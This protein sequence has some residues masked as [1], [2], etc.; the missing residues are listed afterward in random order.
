MVIY[1][2]YWNGTDFLEM[3]ASSVCHLIWEEVLFIC[4]AGCRVEEELSSDRFRKWIS[5]TVEHSK[6]LKGIFLLGWLEG[7]EVDLQRKNAIKSKDQEAVKPFLD[8][9]EDNCLTNLWI[10]RQNCFLLSAQDFQVQVHHEV[11][12]QRMGEEFK[13]DPILFRTFFGSLEK[14]EMAAANEDVGSAAD[15]LAGLQVD[16]K[17]PPLIK[18]DTVQKPAKPKNLD[19]QLPNG[20]F[21]HLLWN[22]DELSSQKLKILTWMLHDMNIDVGFILKAANVHL[23][24]DGRIPGYQIVTPQP[25]S[26]SHAIDPKASNN[27]VL[28]ETRM[29]FVFRGEKTVLPTIYGGLD[30]LGG[31]TKQARVCWFEYKG[32]MYI[33]MHRESETQNNTGSGNFPK[34]LDSK[35]TRVVTAGL[36][37]IVVVG[38]PSNPT[39][40]LGTSRLLNANA[41]DQQKYQ[42][43]RFVDIF[44]RHGFGTNQVVFP[45]PPRWV[46]KDQG[47]RN[48]FILTKNLQ[49]AG[50]PGIGYAFELKGA[51]Q[52]VKRIMGCEAI[53]FSLND[54][55]ATDQGTSKEIKKEEP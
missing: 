30:T 47:M 29:F 28:G 25:C 32:V 51:T 39:Y 22:M 15:G 55:P 35:I 17:K 26:L 41:L 16:D 42:S 49:L 53:F 34:F 36:K 2:K 14:K 50:P 4:V 37:G 33:C 38:I 11:F 18:T 23:R 31:G 27:A 6:D 54:N 12:T 45:A 46:N 3:T 52:P 24:P 13:N 8:L 40:E 19:A 9:I 44:I 48:A 20:S 1:N 10:H 5:E 21:T 43:K 7:R